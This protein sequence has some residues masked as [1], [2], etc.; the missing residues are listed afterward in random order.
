MWSLAGAL[1]RSDFAAVRRRET[2]FVANST[3]R[4]SDYENPLDVEDADGDTGANGDNVYH[5]TVVAMA[6]VFPKPGGDGA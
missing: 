3:R 6:G 1:T 4:R 2:P 5:V